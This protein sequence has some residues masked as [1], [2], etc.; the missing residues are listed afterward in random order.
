MRKMNVLVRAEL[1]HTLPG[2]PVLK[3]RLAET[4]PAVQKE[5]ME[6]Q[7]TALRKVVRIIE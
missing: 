7:A 6:N 4:P 2:C 1:V 5:Q 3:E